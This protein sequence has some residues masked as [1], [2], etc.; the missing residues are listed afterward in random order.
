MWLCDSIISEDY[1]HSRG[2]SGRTSSYFGLR[3]EKFARARPTS[4][5]QVCTYMVWLQLLLTYSSFALTTDLCCWPI[6]PR[7]TLN[8]QIKVHT[9]FSR[10]LSIIVDHCRSLLIIVDH[11]WSLLIIVDHC[12]SLLI[13]VDHCR[14][15][16]IIVDHCRSL[17]IIVDQH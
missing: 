10:S 13:I 16:S 5:H 2:G 8:T 4:K 1:T 15:L 7:V 6:M 11:C 3:L 9:I 14:S 17:S 12:W